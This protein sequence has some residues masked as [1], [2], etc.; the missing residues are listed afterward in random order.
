MRT[1][2][3][4]WR[5]VRRGVAGC[6][7]P[8]SAFAQAAP[9][10]Q[11]PAGAPADRRRGRPAGAREQPRHPDRAIRPAGRGPEHRAGARRLVADVHDHAAEHEHRLAEQQLPVRRAGHE[12]ERR[13]LQLPTSA[14]QQALPWGG[15]YSVGWDSSRSTTTNI[16][17][18]FSPQLR[19]SLA[20]DLRAAAAA[21][22]QHRQRAPAA[23]RQ[24]RR[25]ARSPT[26]TLRQ[27]VAA[28]TRTVR[29]AYW[30][31]AFAIASL[32]VQR[33]SLELAQE[34]LR[35]TRARVEIGTTP[36]IDIVEAEAE[37][38][39]REEAVDRRRSADRDRRGHAAGAVYDPDMPDFWT[40][41]IEPA[42]LPPF[43]PAPVDVDARVRN[44]LD[45]RTDLQQ[46]RKTLE[47]DRHQHPLPPATRRCRTSPPASTTA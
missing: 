13:P 26:S 8:V 27:T 32:D 1:T 5:P 2:A 46:A 25:T 19:S 41:R 16:F 21:R 17:S 18:N 11:A 12:D 22:L 42:D 40:L 10:A 37:V 7:T 20:L 35:N 47:A 43:Q 33:Q 15:R 34:S 39:Q 45:R 4:R 14:S 9:A 23:A 28:T 6:G 31:L 30:D 36:P 24:R 3:I 29:N 44:A 38:A